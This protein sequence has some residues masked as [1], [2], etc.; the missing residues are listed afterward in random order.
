MYLK[1]N[2]L[3]KFILLNILSN[4]KLIEIKHSAN[5]IFIKVPKD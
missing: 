4:L 2:Q 3:D 5:F 1:F